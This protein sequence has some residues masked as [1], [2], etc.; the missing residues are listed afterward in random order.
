MNRTSDPSPAT[1]P[2]RPSDRTRRPPEA[3][4]VPPAPPVA[5]ATRPR[6]RGSPRSPPGPP[7]RFWHLHARKHPNPRRQTEGVPDGP[8][9]LRKPTRGYQRESPSKKLLPP[10][11]RDP[12]EIHGI[13][14]TGLTPAVPYQRQAASF[15]VIAL[16]GTS[17]ASARLQRRSPHLKCTTFP[18]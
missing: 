14:R 16:N 9:R 10:K 17:A 15:Q 3:E 1:R 7:R 11:Q 13:P 12:V 18:W 2:V 5:P 8:L 4:R 6:C